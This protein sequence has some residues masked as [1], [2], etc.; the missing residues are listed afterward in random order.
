M[1]RCWPKLRTG[2]TKN[3][4]DGSLLAMTSTSTPARSV[5][6]CSCSPCV[7]GSAACHISEQPNEQSVSVLTPQHLK[8]LWFVTYFGAVW[9]AFAPWELVSICWFRSD[10]RAWALLSLN[11]FWYQIPANLKK[12]QGNWIWMLW[13]SVFCTVEITFLVLYCNLKDTTHSE[14]EHRWPWKTLI[15]GILGLAF[16]LHSARFLLTVLVVTYA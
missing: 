12:K 9:F 16:A 14:V 7:G 6:E 8:Q 2:S 11:Q 1:G 4:Q 10:R 3:A 13:L 5:Y 15:Q